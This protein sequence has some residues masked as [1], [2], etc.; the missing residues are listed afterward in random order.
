MVTGLEHIIPG[1][2][3][4]FISNQRDIMLDASFFAKLTTTDTQIPK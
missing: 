4:V 1:E 3:Y 2:Q